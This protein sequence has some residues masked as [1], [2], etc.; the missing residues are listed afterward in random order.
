MDSQ[1]ADI[2]LQLVFSGECVDGH[3]PQAVRLALVDALA[4]DEKRAAHLFSGER[5][6]LRRNVGAAA[7]QRHIARFALM[8]AVLHAET[9]VPRK[10]HPAPASTKSARPAPG[11]VSR[12][13][14]LRWA[15]AAL[16]IGGSLVVGLLLGPGLGTLWPEGQRPDAS[17]PVAGMPHPAL[18][19]AAAIAPAVPATPATDAE[20]AQDMPAA[21][22]REYKLRYLA[23]PNHKAF[24]ISTGG[25]YAWHAGAASE[26]EARERALSGCMGTP[27]SAGG[28]RVVDANGD[29]QE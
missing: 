4:L 1:R 6:V 18:P 11:R 12:R 15:A 19:S 24:A 5:V 7:A 28:C 25:A 14:P 27:Q 21:A 20:L 9:S 29:W 16:F 8:G 13:R 17:Q 10:Q 23:A 2:R 26:N 3:E 22:I